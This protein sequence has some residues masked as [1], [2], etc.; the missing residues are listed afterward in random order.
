LGFQKPLLLLTL[1]Q[2]LNGISF[3]S[4]VHVH[5]VVVVIIIVVVVIVIV[6]VVVDVVVDVD[7]QI[8]DDKHKI[9][10]TEERKIAFLSRQD[11]T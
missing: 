8:E 2:F 9:E 3:P 7:D 10:Q 1:D 11:L 4:S 5:I 6:V